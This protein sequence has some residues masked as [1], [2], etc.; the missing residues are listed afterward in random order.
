VPSSQITPSDITFE[1]NLLTKDL[2][3]I[4]TPYGQDKNCWESKNSERVQISGNTIENCFPG[5]QT[6]E[7]ILL[8]PR[9]GLGN[10]VQY[11]SVVS[12]TTITGNTIQAGVGVSV[13]GLDSNCPSVPPC[14]YSARSLLAGNLVNVSV[15]PNGVA[16]SYG[17]CVQI[18]EAQDLILY[19][20][21]CTTDGMQ[22][23]FVDTAPC[24]ACSVDF[25]S[26]NAD[27]AGQGIIGPAAFFQGAGDNNT[28]NNVAVSG[29]TQSA[30][31]LE[32]L[33]YCSTCVLK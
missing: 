20:M 13:A 26:F 11:F 7:G 33:P 23:L 27:F 21:S 16:G 12:D 22:S 15:A 25:A 28:I 6:G 8:T 32:W 3:W 17:W 1:E 24:T 30:F 4:G 9:I 2:S 19:R 14:V 31:N 29:I 10:P 5:A 18:D